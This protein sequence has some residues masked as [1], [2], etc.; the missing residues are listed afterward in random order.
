MGEDER[1]LRLEALFVAHARTVLAYARRRTDPVTADDVLSDVFVVAWRR[2]DEVPADP[3]PWLLA[4]ARRVLANQQRGEQR[5]AKLAE[6]LMANTSRAQVS[7]ELND[8]AL[9]QALASL[10]ERDRE[11]LLLVAWEDL[12]AERAAA[13]LGCSP[14]TFSVRIHRARKRLAGALAAADAARS[15][16][17][18]E[19]CN[20]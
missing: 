20:D 16:T 14:Q 11:V 10:N 5:R 19:A 4:C 17:T 7:V 9:A 15:P 1:R 18:M 13:V 12:S 8:G 2:L 6:R 3:A